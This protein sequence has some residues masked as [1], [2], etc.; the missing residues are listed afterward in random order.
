MHSGGFKPN[1]KVLIFHAKFKKFGVFKSCLACQN[2]VRHVF[3]SLPCFGLFYLA[4]KDVAW[5]FLKR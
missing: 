2:A 4:E 3:R 5:H 1:F